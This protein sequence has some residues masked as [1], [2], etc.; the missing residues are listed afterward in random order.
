M[1][2]L[3]I[4]SGERPSRPAHPSCTDD[5]WT[6]IQSCWDDEPCLRPGVS[7]VSEMLLSSRISLDVGI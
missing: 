3:A 2:A 5:L 6:L 7:K 4:L 1:A